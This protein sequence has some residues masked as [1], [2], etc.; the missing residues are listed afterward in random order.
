MAQWGVDYNIGFL[1]PLCHWCQKTRSNILTISLCLFTQ[2]PLSFFDQWW[3]CLAQLLL[4]V[5]K[6]QSTL[7]ITAIA[8]VTKVNKK[9]S[10]SGLFFN[11]KPIVW[12]IKQ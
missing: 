8:L 2:T 11:W 6:L 4:M 9:L 3:S 10:Y 7:P 5:C 12:N 1:S